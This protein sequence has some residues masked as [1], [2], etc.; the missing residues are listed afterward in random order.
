[1]T[2][3]LGNEYRPGMRHH[4]EISLVRPWSLWVDLSDVVIANYGPTDL[5]DLH[6]R[7][8]LSR[9]TIITAAEL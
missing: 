5:S 7:K 1:M 4:V 3:P 2:A 8:V 6:L 9:T